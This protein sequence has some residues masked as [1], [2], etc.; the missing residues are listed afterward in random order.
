MKCIDAVVWLFVTVVE[1]TKKTKF[2]TALRVTLLN[3]DHAAAA[4]VVVVVVWRSNNLKENLQRLV[5]NF[6]PFGFCCSMC[7]SEK[8]R[9]RES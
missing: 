4:V 5:S 1:R 7:L 3:E 8:E 9:G 6:L 2:F